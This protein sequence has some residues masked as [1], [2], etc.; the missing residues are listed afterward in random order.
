MELK[1][2]AAYAFPRMPTRRAMLFESFAR[3]E[4]G[5]ELV[6][7]FGV[8]RGQRGMLVSSTQAH[9][10]SRHV[11]QLVLEEGGAKL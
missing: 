7:V 5:P 3:S 1:K 10:P 9:V 6:F 2:G 8:A 11:E 4:E